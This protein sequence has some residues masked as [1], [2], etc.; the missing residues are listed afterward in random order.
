MESPVFTAK[1]GTGRWVGI[2]YVLDKCP[3]CNG[4]KTMMFLGSGR[5]WG[6]SKCKKGGDSLETFRH[7][8]A[9]NPL[10]ANYVQFIEDPVPPDEI[11]VVSQYVNPYREAVIPLGFGTMDN[12]IGGLAE[13]SMTV[14]TGKRGEGKSTMLSQITLN[15]IQN[16]HNVCFYSGELSAGRFQAWTFAQAAGAKYM[17]AK[18]DQF[19]ATR[20]MVQER[21]EKA[22][23]QWMDEHM[24][25]YDSS[26][27]KANERGTILKMFA[28][29]RQ[30]YG[31]DL[32]VVD[33][34]MTAKNDMDGADDALR[35]Q[36]NFAAELLNF[37]R[38]NSVA[39]I[40]VAHPKKGE[41]EDIN[42]GVAGLADIT[43]LASNVI[44]IRRCNDGERQQHGCDSLV[45][46]AK[47]RD[48]GD[49]GSHRFSF[50]PKSRR[51]VPMDGSCISQYG[52][53]KLLDQQK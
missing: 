39:V 13:A 49:T 31:S 22:I 12:M 52:W 38:E 40:L 3:L 53:T 28:K 19:G 1:L 25:L 29:A 48:Y 10:T 36:A 18:I 44:Q 37:A 16:G 5:L 11:I 7:H 45:T 24:V 20:W 21:A 4:T 30:Y 43:N 51:F 46:V 50:E 34:L 27:I 9:Q 23:R 32:F 41:H 8:L 47:N 17:E 15:T 14:I 6:C 33:N 26:R 2:R 35:A 42:D